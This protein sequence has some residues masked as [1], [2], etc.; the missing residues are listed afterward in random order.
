MG[1]SIKKITGRFIHLPVILNYVVNKVNKPIAFSL[2][3]T[4][5]TL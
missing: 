5:L 3:D 4:T 1:F 2:S